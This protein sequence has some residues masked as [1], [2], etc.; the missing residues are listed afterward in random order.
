MYADLIDRVDE[1]RAAAMS[2]DDLGPIM[3]LYGGLECYLGGAGVGINS[4]ASRKPIFDSIFVSC[5]TSLR[6]DFFQ[7]TFTKNQKTCNE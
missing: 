1:A 7:Q 3:E 2:L 5:A 4:C 6:V